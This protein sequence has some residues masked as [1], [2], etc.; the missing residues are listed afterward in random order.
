MFVI[1]NHFSDM[2]VGII[3]S[4]QI[5]PQAFTTLDAA[6]KAAA[7]LLREAQLNFNPNLSREGVID[8]TVEGDELDEIPNAD[9]HTC[10]LCCVGETMEGDFNTYHNAFL[11]SKV[12]VAG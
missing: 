12:D 3:N 9:F 8:F 4:V 7:G 1:M 10:C 2:E 11:I 5:N 6:K